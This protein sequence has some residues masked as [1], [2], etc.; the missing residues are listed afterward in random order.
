ME[1]KSS[2]GF[3]EREEP[4]PEDYPGGRKLL[5][6]EPEFSVFEYWFPRPGQLEIK[7]CSSIRTAYYKALGKIQKDVE[8]NSTQANSTQAKADMLE[9]FMYLLDFSKASARGDKSEWGHGH[10]ARKLAGAIGRQLMDINSAKSQREAE[11][12]LARAVSLCSTV[13]KCFAGAVGAIESKKRKGYP[14][15][16]DVFKAAEFLILGEKCRPDKATIRLLVLATRPEF[17]S[18]NRKGNWDRLFTNIGFAGFPEVPV[19]V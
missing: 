16:I 5:L 12:H 15:E 13:L 7:W 3:L 6:E 1:S 9:A 18:K 4:L 19:S 2:R 11:D 10:I 8:S 17:P 14:D